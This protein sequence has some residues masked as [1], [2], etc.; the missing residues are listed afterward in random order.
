MVEMADAHAAS[1]WA[2]VAA[3][4]VDAVALS[5]P[6][7]LI[8][9]A[10]FRA[11][12][13]SIRAGDPAAF[14]GLAGID[15]ALFAA[16]MAAVGWIEGQRGYTPGKFVMHLRVVDASSGELLGGRRGLLRRSMWVLG[17][18][19]VFGW[20]SIAWDPRRQGWH[21]KTAKS[22]VVKDPRGFQPSPAN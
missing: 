14:W 6:S 12:E 17:G 22:V 1:R 19:L 2:R 13:P 20:A 9:A 4:L 21:D 10:C 15:L 16:V 11:L 5:I 18:W 8:F 7:A 3:F